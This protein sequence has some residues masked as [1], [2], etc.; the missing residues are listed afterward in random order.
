MHDEV[1]KLEKTY[2][3]L[4]EQQSLNN[5][6]T[7]REN[8]KDYNLLKYLIKIT[9]NKDINILKSIADT[10]INEISNGVVVIINKKE[11]DSLNIIIKSNSNIDAGKLIKDIS[12]VIQ[13]NG[14]GSKTFAQGGAKSKKSSTELESIVEKAIKEN[15]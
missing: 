11:E 10:L 1:K 4:K 8:I 13:G 15:A 7:Y 14:G 6:D 3:N 12:S 9:E 2:Y 5:L